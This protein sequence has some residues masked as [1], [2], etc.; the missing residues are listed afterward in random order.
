MRE[1]RIC[2][3]IQLNG[4]AEPKKEHRIAR[5][6]QSPNPLQF[7]I[8]ENPYPQNVLISE[9]IRTCEVDEN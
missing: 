2:Q 1:R 3:K 5:N 6:K 8:A 9:R 7:K 4:I